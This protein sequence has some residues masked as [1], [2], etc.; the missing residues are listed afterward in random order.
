M[1]DN[2]FIWRGYRIGF[3]SHGRILRSL[4]MLHNESVNVWTHLIGA[5]MFICLIG[6]TFTY[7]APPAIESPS[8]ATRSLFNIQGWFS[9]GLLARDRDSAALGSLLSLEN[10]SES[11]DKK[12][13][14]KDALNNPMKE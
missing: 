9:D 14:F 5:I 11:D 7:M 10:S 2:E 12:P 1:V 6:Y 3:N 8:L 13:S 4:F